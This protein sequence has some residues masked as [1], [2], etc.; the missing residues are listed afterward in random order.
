MNNII[1]W[2]NIK[3]KFSIVQIVIVFYLTQMGIRENQ[4]NN[5][6]VRN[7]TTL[8]YQICALTSI[9]GGM[10]TLSMTSPMAYAQL[11]YDRDNDSIENG[12][13][14]CPDDPNPQCT[15]PYTEPALPGINAPI[16]SA[17]QSAQTPDPNDLDGDGIDVE[18]IDIVPTINFTFSLAFVGDLPSPS[19]LDEESSQTEQSRT[20]EQ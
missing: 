3:R 15:V 17:Q 18:G 1:L 16:D 9:L 19:S 11:L 6:T 4:K 13:D 5:F 12:N 14:P 7:V 8:I 20:A 10:A 2:T